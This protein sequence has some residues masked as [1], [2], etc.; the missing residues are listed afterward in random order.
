M[1]LQRRSFLQA[2]PMA[3][4]G[5]AG[6]NH[7]DRQNGADNR[8]ATPSNRDGSLS[9]EPTTPGGDEFEPA[10]Q[11]KYRVKTP[12]TVFWRNRR[13]TSQTVRVTLKIGHSDNLQEVLNQTYEFTPRNST[14]IG[15]FEQHGTYHFTVETGEQQYSKSVYISLRQ[16][17]DCNRVSAVVV[18]EKSGISIEVWQT[19]I[20]CPP[21]TVTP[22]PNDTVGE[23]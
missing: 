7:L 4:V 14:E 13:N 22:S 10:E 5:I 1:P 20:G 23:E 17:A 18:L 8:T 9:Y 6:C 21:L 2:L 19:A 15:A 3:T 16:L 11:P 12:A